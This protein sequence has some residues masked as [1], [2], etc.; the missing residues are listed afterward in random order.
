[1][2]SETRPLFQEL[3]SPKFIFCNKVNVS[4]TCPSFHES[5]IAGRSPARGSNGDQTVVRVDRTTIEVADV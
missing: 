3:M 2:V 1:M 4:A 5:L